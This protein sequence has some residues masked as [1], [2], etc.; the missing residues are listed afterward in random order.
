M[1]SAC[2]HL[3]RPD[4]IAA[5]QMIKTNAD[6]QDAFIKIAERFIGLGTPNR[7]QGFVLMP[8]LAAIELLQSVNPSVQ[9]ANILLFRRVCVNN[10]LHRVIKVHIIA[11]CAL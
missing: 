3:D 9:S 11:L 5:R 7:F 1:D 2:Q 8:I 6:L 10:S 4:V